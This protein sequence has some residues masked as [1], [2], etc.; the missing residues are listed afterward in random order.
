MPS[1]PP[2]RLG[3]NTPL[4]NWLNRFLEWAK[5]G[6]PIS[7]PVCRASETNQ[8]ML[9]YPLALGQGGTPATTATVELLLF[10]SA[11]ANYTVCQNAAGL[12]IPVAKPQELRNNITKRNIYNLD[13]NYT[14][15]HN[16]AGGGPSVDQYAY[17]MRQVSYTPPGGV[18]T[19]V[20]QLYVPP[21]L[22]PGKITNTG[23]S[24]SASI[25]PAMLVN[26]STGVSLDPLDTVTP[27]GTVIK[28]IEISH[29]A[30]AKSADQTI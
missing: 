28:Y 23:G 17:N 20:K 10:K 16:P 30:W 3:G 13:F 19:T 14:Y 24:V 27:A 4:E 18:L 15:P 26:G 6:R 2:P 7:S 5:S 9:L 1:T 21:Y 12:I 29:R 11:F 22:L 8:G 25:V